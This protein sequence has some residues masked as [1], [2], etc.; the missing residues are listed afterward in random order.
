MHNTALRKQIDFEVL[1]GQLQT[2]PLFWATFHN[3]IYVVELLLRH[4]ANAGF[5]DAVGFSPFLLAVQVC[6]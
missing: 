5:T 1:G 2:T 3:H 4:G 6:I